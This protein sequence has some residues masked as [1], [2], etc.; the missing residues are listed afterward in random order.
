MALVLKKIVNLYFYLN[1]E[2]SGE[3]HRWI[4]A[5]RLQIRQWNDIH[6]SDPRVR[7][8]LLM[9]NPFYIFA[10]LAGYLLFVLKWGPQFMKDRKPYDL[11]RIMIIYNIIQIIACARLVFQASVQF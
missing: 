5:Q 2:V 10:I 11:N 7:D 3:C 4:R 8:F 1:D 6:I 9:S